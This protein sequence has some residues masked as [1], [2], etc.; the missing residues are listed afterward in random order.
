M[1][2]RS[3]MVIATVANSRISRT[4]EAC[5]AHTIKGMGVIVVALLCRFPCLR[6]NATA[7]IFARM[8]GARGTVAQAMRLVRK[9]AILVIAN[10]TMLLL[11][12]TPLR[13][14]WLLGIVILVARNDRSRRDVRTL[15]CATQ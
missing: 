13:P 4:A 12:R 9:A 7:A 10:A 11:L 6:G 3:L 15:R 14:S 8:L 5:G 2:P 1:L